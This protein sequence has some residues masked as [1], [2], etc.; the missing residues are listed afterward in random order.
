[1]SESEGEIPEWM[2]RFHSLQF[3]SLFEMQVDA[4]DFIWLFYCLF[5]FCFFLFSI[6]RKKPRGAVQ[7]G[8]WKPWTKVGQLPLFAVAGQLPATKCR[9]LKY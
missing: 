7:E 5:V 9:R 4:K 2:S 3:R 6:E 1:M 8:F